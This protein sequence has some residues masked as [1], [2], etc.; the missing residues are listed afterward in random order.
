MQRF[1]GKV[2]L[3][4]GT[5]PNI[6]SGLALMLAKYGAMVACTDM[7]PEMAEKAR[8][9]FHHVIGLLGRVEWGALMSREVVFSEF[10]AMPF[11]EYMLVC[12]VDEE[13]APR[14]VASLRA[15]FEGF[16]EMIGEAASVDVVERETGAMVVLDIQRSPVQLAAG[17]VA[18]VVILSTSPP[19]VRRRIAAAVERDE[20]DRITTSA[21]LPAAS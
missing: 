7:R 8:A 10:L 9:V 12:R 17:S 6:G 3:V 1:A 15:M 2:A 11:P 13:K 21:T 16:A 18:D 20:V 5:G 19:L 4:T 14:H